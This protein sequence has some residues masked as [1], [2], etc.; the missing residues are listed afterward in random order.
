MN[1]IPE[2]ESTL[3]ENWAKGGTTKLF[4]IMRITSKNR[5]LMPLFKQ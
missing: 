3:Q 5:L 1:L 4:W 2:R